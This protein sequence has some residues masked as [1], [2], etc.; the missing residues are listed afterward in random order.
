MD[1]L[2]RRTTIYIY[3]MKDDTLTSPTPPEIRDTECFGIF[4]EGKA[5]QPRILLLDMD[6]LVGFNVLTPTATFVLIK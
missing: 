3:S 2:S 4:F 6:F 1:R 5:W